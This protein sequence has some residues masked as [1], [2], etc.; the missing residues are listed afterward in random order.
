MAAS[1][2]HTAYVYTVVLPVKST[3]PAGRL[4]R[5]RR[6]FAAA[7]RRSLPSHSVISCCAASSG[8]GSSG[9]A[10]WNSRTVDVNDGHDKPGGR[11][12]HRPRGQPH[13]RRRACVSPSALIRHVNDRRPHLRRDAADEHWSGRQAR[14]RTRNGGRAQGG[15]VFLSGYRT[16]RCSASMADDEAGRRVDGPVAQSLAAV[17]S[18]QVAWRFSAGRRG[19]SSA[20][21]PV[22]SD[23]EKE[24]G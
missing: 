3:L 17:Q 16:D 22:A 5:L 20:W 10:A 21:L 13:R 19:I 14:P 2:V 15:A 24:P 11:P 4:P 7:R 23:S 1:P 18:T 9:W 12:L 6:S 8:S